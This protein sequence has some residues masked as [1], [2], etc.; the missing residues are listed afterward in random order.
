M[1][2]NLWLRK[3]VYDKCAQFCIRFCIIV[4]HVMSCLPLLSLK[5]SK[6]MANFPLK[7]TLSLLFARRI[8]V[9]DAFFKSCAQQAGETVFFVNS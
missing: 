3:F 4:Y 1:F 5:V 7:H 2:S 9:M 6:K 8:Q